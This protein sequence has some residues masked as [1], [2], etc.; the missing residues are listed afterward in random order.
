MRVIACVEGHYEI[1]EVSFGKLYMWRP[2]HIVI[3]CGCGRRLAL[4]NTITVC[5]CVTDLSATLRETPLSGR[6]TKTFPWRYAEGREDARYLPRELLIRPIERSRRSLPTHEMHALNVT[7]DRLWLP[8]PQYRAEQ[9]M[10]PHDEEGS[11]WAGIFIAMIGVALMV[12]SF[13]IAGEPF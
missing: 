12:L 5:G 4:A 6:G 3:E 10:S 7:E 1:Q 13:A 2:G 11:T 9:K 8:T